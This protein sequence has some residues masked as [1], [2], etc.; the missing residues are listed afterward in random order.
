MGTLNV[1]SARC[2][3]QEERGG[4]KANDERVIKLLT[5]ALATEILSILRYQRQYYRT[6]GSGARH[7][8]AQFLQLV[9]EEQAHADHLAV[10]IVQLG[11]TLD[12]SHTQLLN[13]NDAEYVEGHSL[14]EMLRADLL[15]ERSA[16][17]NDRLSRY[18]GSDDSAGLGADTGARRSACGE[19]GRSFEG[20]GVTPRG[21]VRGVSVRH[22]QNLKRRKRIYGLP[23]LSGVAGMRN[24]Q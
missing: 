11:G 17:R 19:F 12:L 20:L 16:P 21:Y 1:S 24:V 9:T 13:Q 4:A 7:V 3:T 5:E 10:R 22:F 6:V 15:A 23:T 14:A 8:K 18:R 2:R